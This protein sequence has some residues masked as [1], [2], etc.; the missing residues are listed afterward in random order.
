MKILCLYSCHQTP[1]FPVSGFQVG[2]RAVPVSFSMD[3]GLQMLV[4]GAYY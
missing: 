2:D 1:Q 4:D 3:V